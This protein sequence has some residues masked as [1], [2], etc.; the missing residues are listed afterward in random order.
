M[1]WNISR[2]YRLRNEIV[3]NAAIKSNIQPSVSHIR[4]YLTFVL[5]SILSFL[6]DSPVDTNNDGQISIEDYFITQEIKLANLK[7]KTIRE[8]NRINNPMEIFY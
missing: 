4:Y 5:Y 1:K 8:Y 2:L 6:A 3:H 7:R